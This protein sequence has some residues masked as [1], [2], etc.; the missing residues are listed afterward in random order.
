MFNLER[1]SRWACAMYHNK[2][3]WREKTVMVSRFHQVLRLEGSRKN[4]SEGSRCCG[5]HSPQDCPW[6]K[7]IQPAR[8]S[9]SNESSHDDSKFWVIRMCQRSFAVY[10][11]L[12]SWRSPQKTC[13]KPRKLHLMQL[14][15]DQDSNQILFLRQR[16]MIVNML[17]TSIFVRG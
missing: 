4:V 9:V 17:D 10:W 15:P 2:L 11:A 16:R 14:V 5:R 1:T 6:P 12:I 3:G 13:K 8:L 7:H